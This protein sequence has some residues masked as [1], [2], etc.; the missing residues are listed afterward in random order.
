MAKMLVLHFSVTG[1]T[2]KMAN[3]IVEGASEIKGVE[4]ELNKDV[5]APEKLSNF[6]AIII[7]VPTITGQM[8]NACSNFLQ[9]VSY[10]K[11]NLKGKIG[12]AFGSFGWNGLAPD[13][14]LKVMKNVFEMTVVEP[15]LL[16]KGDP[17]SVGLDKC[18]KFGKEVAQKLIT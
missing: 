14:V 5:I 12:G 9:S 18:R 17:N 10:K 3:A 15:P 11:V 4:T 16:V 13:Q 7:G 6:D 2:E 1:H 8:P